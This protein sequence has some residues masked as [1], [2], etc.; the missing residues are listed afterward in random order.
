MLQAAPD[1]AF[2]AQQVYLKLGEGEIRDITDIQDDL[3]EED[4]V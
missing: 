2:G 4:R 3:R 1:R